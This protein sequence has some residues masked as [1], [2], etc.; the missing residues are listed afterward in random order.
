MIIKVYLIILIYVYIIFQSSLEKLDLD[1][2]L[3]L[4]KKN[5]DLFL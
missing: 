3:L 4:L 2:I 5:I 1:K